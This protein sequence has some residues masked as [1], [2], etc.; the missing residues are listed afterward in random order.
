MAKKN[1]KRKTTKKKTARKKATKKTA[2]KQKIDLSKYSEAQL[3]AALNRKRSTAIGA[4]R[5]KRA[6][7]MRRVSDLDRR[8]QHLNGSAARSRGGGAR[9]TRGELAAAVL[10]ELRRERTPKQLLESCS[11]LIGGRNKGSSIE[12]KDTRRRRRSGSR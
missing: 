1:A 9:A 11:H 12:S 6:D 4:I 3:E 8:I 7:L 2:T 10:R 5:E